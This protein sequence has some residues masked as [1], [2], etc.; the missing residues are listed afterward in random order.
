MGLSGHCHIKY[1]LHA[2][3]RPKHSLNSFSAP[4]LILGTEDT[5][6]NETKFISQV[7]NKKNV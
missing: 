1:L 2:G 7:L 6:V 3:L 5:A 4:K